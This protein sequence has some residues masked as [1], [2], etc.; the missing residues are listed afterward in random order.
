M[1]PV[2]ASCAFFI[3][4]DISNAKIPPKIPQREKTEGVAQIR[5][6]KEDHEKGDQE[7]RM[8][9]PQTGT[10]G[11]VIFFDYVNARLR[12]TDCSFR[13]KAGVGDRTVC[14]AD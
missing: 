1:I 5:T 9:L 8:R 12:V 7:G 13:R 11:G 3:L 4:Y 2:V 10:A 6:P 14:T